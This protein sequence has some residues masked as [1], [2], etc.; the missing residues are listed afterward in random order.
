MPE[1]SFGTGDGDSDDSGGC[2]RRWSQGLL[3]LSLTVG[4]AALALHSLR[5]AHSLAQLRSDLDALQANAAASTAAAPASRLSPE[6]QP[7]P[8]RPEQLRKLETRL[9]QLETQLKQ[10]KDAVDTTKKEEAPREANSDLVGRIE[11]LEAGAKKTALSIVQTEKVGGMVAN[12]SESL[13]TEMEELERKLDTC[14][15]RMCPT[16][17]E[18]DWADDNSSSSLLPS[19]SPSS[20]ASESP[21][22]DSQDSHSKTRRRPA[23]KHPKPH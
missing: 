8:L 16:D 5:L 19:P 22:P 21:E 11:A 4:L 6:S 7:P 10:S 1:I 9:S 23:P 17:S 3:F 13:K 14:E 15:T 18:S 20:D 12:I 2:C